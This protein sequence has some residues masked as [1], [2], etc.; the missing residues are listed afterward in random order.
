M[1]LRHAAPEA[2]RQVIFFVSR[3]D[4]LGVNLPAGYALPVDNEVAAGQVARTVI[5]ARVLSV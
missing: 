4:K 3:K 5:S 1:D 2:S